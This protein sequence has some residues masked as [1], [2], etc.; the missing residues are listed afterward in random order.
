MYPRKGAVRVGAD[1]DIVIW[2][3][4]YKHIISHKT[5]H[6]KVDHNIF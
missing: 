1:A 3:P 6:Q 2:D 5:H 4:N